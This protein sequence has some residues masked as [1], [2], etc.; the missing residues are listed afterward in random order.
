MKKYYEFVNHLN[1]N[2]DLI[3]QMPSDE[4]LK[5]LY[6]HINYP[7][8]RREQWYQDAK[9]QQEQSKNRKEMRAFEVGMMQE[10]DK[11]ELLSRLSD[12]I[13][14]AHKDPSSTF[15][16]E[17]MTLM[18]SHKELIRDISF[19]KDMKS[20]GDGIKVVGDF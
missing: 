1:E 8:P 18:Y 7:G 17:L 15:M 6:P 14:M 2:V 19:G 20:K 11:K 10:R 3:D 4:E 12:M 16:E 9:A 13:T 5:V